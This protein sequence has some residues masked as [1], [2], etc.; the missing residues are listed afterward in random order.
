MAITD[1]RLF[2]EATRLRLLTEL[3]REFSAATDD[4]DTLLS[5]ITRRLSEMFGDLAV[6]RLL[7]ADGQ[8]L[9]SSPAFHHPDPEI[10]ALARAA[11]ATHP[12]RVGEGITGR[13]AATGE[14]ILVPVVDKAPFLAAFDP[15]RRSLVER[16]RIGS[17]VAAPLLSFGRTIGVVSLT[18]NDGKTPFDEDDLRLLQDVAAHA[19]LALANARSYA[20][21]RAAHAAA[22]RA[23]QALHESEEAHRLL[24]EASPLPLFVFD[25]ETFAPLAVNE[26]TLRLYGYEHDEFMQL[27]VTDLIVSGHET[28]RSRLAAQGDAEFAGVT[29]YRRKDGSQFIA[30]YTTRALSFIDRRARITV[31]KDVTERSEA[32]Q[33]R[34]LLAAI[35]E[36]SNDAI[37]SERLDGTITS[38]NGAAQRLFGYSAE[39][40]LGKPVTMVVPPDR[41][42]ESKKLLERVAAGERVDHYETIRRR[43]DG[44]EVPVAISLAPITDASGKVVGASKTTRDLTAQ[45]KAAEALHETEEQLRHAQ[46]MEAVGRLAGGI[47]HD[48]NNLLSVILSYSSIIAEELRPGDPLRGDVEEI[49]KAGTR[50]ADL[51]RQLL[52]FSRQEVVEPKVLDLNEVLT[53]M[54]R[55][56]R[57]LLGEDVDLVYLRGPALGRVR[58]D[59]SHLDQVIV[60]LAVNARDAMPR[61]GK[62]TIETDNVVLNETFAREHLGITPG[63]YV[64]FAMTDTGTG[65]DKATLARIFEPFF[66][67]KEKGKGTG[68]GLSTVFGIVQQ[69]KG[70]IWV[71][72][73]VGTGT[74]FRVYLPMVD[75][76]PDDIVASPAPS[77]LDGTETIL[78]VEDEDQIRAVARG[79]L[80]RHGYNVIEAC[81]GGEALLHCESYPGTIHLLLT[82]IVMP[83]MSGPTLAERL[84]AIRPGV[85]VLCMSG[86]TDDALVRHG[87]MDAA[88]AY[89]QKPFTPEKLT[90]KVRMVLD[91]ET[92]RRSLS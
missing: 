56:L 52:M 87:A 25:V 44:S 38:W 73:E 26:A 4:F 54:E 34:A 71:Y 65:M 21:E 53:D 51:T 59:P 39:E 16:L 9:E 18:R 27:K 7:S 90:R 64:M 74:S 48:F 79:I 49:G 62:L 19:A 43:K 5:V 91:A 47:A 17:V 29:H 86:Y 89:L 3:A 57:R 78:L 76:A 55:M 42:E 36:S 41:L 68:L 80:R 22:L 81:N 58:A 30:E 2:T 33:T 84:L 82:D 92:A 61:G 11:N 35:V 70:S 46:K 13:V 1:A 67:T 24:F 50:A 63:P 88:I 85:K 14:A 60:N 28:A 75:A 69:C 15:E 45:R 77:T 32:E 37:V 6:L 66:T 83:Q 20:A 12:Q 8:V 40:A 10:V 72:S 31:I 23:N